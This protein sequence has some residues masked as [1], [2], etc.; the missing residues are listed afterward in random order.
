MKLIIFIFLKFIQ[1]LTCNYSTINLPPEHVPYYFTANPEIAEKCRIDTECPYKEYLT[2]KKYWGYELDHQWGNQYSVPECP[3]D[4]KGWVKTK[5]DQENTF[6]TQGDFGFVK[7]QIKEL[8]VLCEP[9]FQDDSILECSDHLRYCRGRNI[10]INFTQLASRPDPIRYKMDVL[11]HGDIGGYC[12]L[13]Q[14]ELDKQADHIS[15]LQSWGPE[16]RYFSKLKHRPIISNGDCDVVLEK[17]T[18]IMKID[19]TINMYHHFCD[20]LNLYASLH[21]NEGPEAFSTD[22]HV[23]IWETFTYRSLFED[24]WKAF[25]EHPLWD[26]KTFRGETV[27]FKNVIFPLLPRMIFGLY[28]NTPLIYGC[29]KSGLFHAFSKHMLHRLK[30]PIYRRINRKIKITFLSRDTKYRRVLNEEA[31][32]DSIKDNDEYE[33]NRVIYN[34]NIPFKKQLE[35]SANSDVLVGIHGAGLTHL[36]FLPDWAAVFE[37]YNCED[38]NCYADLARLRGVHYVTWKNTEKLSSE[39]DDSHEGAA[40]AKFANY[41]FDVE[42][43]KRLLKEATDYVKNQASYQEFLNKISPEDQNNDLHDEL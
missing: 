41:S 18:Y 38:A 31:L 19:A 33:V 22:V 37:L 13:N 43:F 9:L 10:M 12:D 17:P 24:S 16:I 35:I 21:L 34:R 39:T 32:L 23:L 6:Y 36:L 11:S 40:H 25:T 42:E 20:F 28:Y 2:E 1:V 27:C 26:L 5:F 15:A 29:R 14:K 8:K 7:Q 3:G 4:H 30:I